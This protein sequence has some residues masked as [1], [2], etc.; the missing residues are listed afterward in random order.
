LTIQLPKEIPGQHFEGLDMLTSLL[1][2]KKSRS[3]KSLV[4]EIGMTKKK[5]IYTSHACT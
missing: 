5:F 1:A 3:A 2:P 4:E